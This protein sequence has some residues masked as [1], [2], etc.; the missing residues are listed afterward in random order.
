MEKWQK[1]LLEMLDV[2]TEEVE[3]F[4]VGVT[5]I[6]ENAI[7]FSEEI[8]EQ[9]QNSLVNEIDQYL[10]EFTEPLFEVY[11]EL[12][13]FVGESDRPFTYIIEPSLTQNP[14][15]I[16]CHHYH[17]HVYNG[18]LLVCGMHPYGWDG[19]SCPDWEQK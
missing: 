5:D 9:V 2:V 15:C 3:K 17:G 1:D 14:A 18:N 7:A 11:W 19:E 8:G 13:E 10:N 12:E 16:G 6:V 4:F